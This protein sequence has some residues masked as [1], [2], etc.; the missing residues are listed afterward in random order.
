MTRDYNYNDLQFPDVA[1]LY[2]PAIKSYYTTTREGGEVPYTLATDQ[3]TAYLRFLEYYF[4]TTGDFIPFNEKD[5][6]FLCEN[7]P[8]SAFITSNR[9]ANMFLDKIRDSIKCLRAAAEVFERIEDPRNISSE[10]TNN[11]LAARYI[12]LATDNIEYSIRYYFSVELSN[13]YPLLAYLS[14]QLK[15]SYVNRTTAS[16]H[17]KLAIQSLYSLRYTEYLFKRDD[18]CDVIKASNYI[19]AK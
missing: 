7:V 18:K 17:I 3:K 2:N 13:I 16:G 6:A 5:S 14:H 4:Y 19:R 8:A 11:M 10:V 12:H 1:V 15:S 9:K